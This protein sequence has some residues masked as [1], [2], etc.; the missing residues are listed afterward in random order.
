MRARG[1]RVVSIVGFALTTG[2]TVPFAL[3]GPQTGV[4]VLGAA[5]LVRG[6]G[7]GMVVVP[8]LSVAFDGLERDEVPHASI[9]TRIGQ[10][11]GGSLGVALLAVVLASVGAATGSSSAGFAVAFWWACGISALAVPLSFALPRRMSSA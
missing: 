10:Q 3:T 5:L 6:L 4:L 11:L 7:I 9:V 8:L 2:A 1:P